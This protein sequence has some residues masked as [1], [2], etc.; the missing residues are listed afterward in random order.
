MRTTRHHFFQSLRVENLDV[1]VLHFNQAFVM[2]L[3][4]RAADGFQFQTQ[5]AAD[6]LT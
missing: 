5:I 6:F 2:E 3:R 1:F 4:Q